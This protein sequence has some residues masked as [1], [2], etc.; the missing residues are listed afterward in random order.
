MPARP[1]RRRRR[2]IGRARILSRPFGRRARALRKLFGSEEYKTW[3][4]K[5]FERDGFACKGCGRSDWIEAHHL[6][7]KHDHPD[8]ALNV[9][10]GMTL[11]GPSTD[12]T[13]CHGRV[14][15]SEYKSLPMLLRLMDVNQRANVVRMARRRGI[16]V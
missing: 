14:T 16:D 8:I 9:N 15:G 13:T 3:R 11:C 10:N 7:R 12:R 6:L 1:P 4:R 5:V 2:R